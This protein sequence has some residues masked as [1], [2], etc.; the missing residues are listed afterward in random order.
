[1]AAKTD[2]NHKCVANNDGIVSR[3]VDSSA[4]III[5]TS[6]ITSLLILFGVQ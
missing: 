2:D 4:Y 3:W 1:M 6:S 5:R